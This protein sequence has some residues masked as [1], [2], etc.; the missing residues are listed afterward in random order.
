MAERTIKNPKHRSAV[1]V[2]RGIP[3]PHATV[4]RHPK[5][6]WKQMR[7]GDSF[8]IPGA[9]ERSASSMAGHAGKVNGMKFVVRTVAGGVRV[10]RV[11]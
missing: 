8:L 2:E 7:V 3:I 10:W 6:P 1:K 5:W 9:K 11:K 4:G